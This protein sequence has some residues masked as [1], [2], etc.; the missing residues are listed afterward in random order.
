[1]PEENVPKSAQQT[2]PQDLTNSDVREHAKFKAVIKELSELKQA[3]ADRTAAEEQSKKDADVKKAE[4]ELRYKDAL[5]LRQ[6]EYDTLKAAH[7]KEIQHRDVTTELM[8]HGFTN[9]L[10]LKG[11]VAGFDPGKGSIE[12]FA[13]GVVE[14]DANKQFLPSTDERK[15][16]K[17]PGHT[18]ATGSKQMSSEQIKAMQQSNK[19]EDRLAAV[20]YLEDY[21]NANH[22]LPP[23]F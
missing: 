5:E 2:D 11:A 16:L 20:K 1:M 15:A 12:D 22:T 18:P 13:K 4:G 14:D 21:F 3:N 6:K 17:P 7:A 23:G 8:K 19:Q 10:F 9:D